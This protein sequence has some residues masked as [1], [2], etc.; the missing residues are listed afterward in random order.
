MQDALMLINGLYKKLLQ[1][2]NYALFISIRNCK[3]I[4]IYVQNSGSYC[5]FSYLRK[6]LN[7]QK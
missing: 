7:F 1:I 3:Y 6:T 2:D 4:T 5:A